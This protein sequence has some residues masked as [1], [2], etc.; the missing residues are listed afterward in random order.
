MVRVETLVSECRDEVGRLRDV[1]AEHDADDMKRFQAIE[2]KFAWWAGVMFMVST[3]LSGVIIALQLW[4]S[5]R[6]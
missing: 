3:V 5:Y 4:A 1:V 6:K 2:V